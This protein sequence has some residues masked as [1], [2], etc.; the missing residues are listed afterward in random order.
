VRQHDGQLRQM[1]IPSIETERLL[2]REWREDDLD[3]YARVCADREVS[4]YLSGPLSRDDTWRQMAMFTGHWTLRGYGT[5]AVE[6]KESGAMIGRIGLHNPEGW[7]GLEVGWTIDR[8]VW[9]RGYATEGGQASLD[10]A[11]RELGAEHVISIIDPDNR[12]SIAVAERLGETFE[13]PYRLRGR[14]VSIYGINR[15]LA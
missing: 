7:P 2:L 10:F 1:E 11:W 8:S 12:L 4:R 15:P 13:R 3:A 5:W 6:E 9:G 14:P